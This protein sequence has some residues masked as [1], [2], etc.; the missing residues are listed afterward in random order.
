MDRDEPPFDTNPN[1]YTAID[2]TD[3]GFASPRSVA[4]KP[5]G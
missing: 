4:I 3:T 1:I 5:V 2:V